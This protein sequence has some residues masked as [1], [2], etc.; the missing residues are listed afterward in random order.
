MAIKNPQPTSAE[1]SAILHDFMGGLDKSPWPEAG[2]SSFVLYRRGKQPKWYR[3]AVCHAYLRLNG[4]KQG[5]EPLAIGSR[6]RV[7]K[8]KDMQ[9][10]SDWWL[11]NMWTADSPWDEVYLK[12]MP[13]LIGGVMVNTPE[14]IK[15]YGFFLYNLNIAGNLLMNFFQASRWQSE[16][17][18]DAQAAYNIWKKHKIDWRILFVFSPLMQGQ[19]KDCPLAPVWRNHFSVGTS[20]FVPQAFVQGQPNPLNLTAP[21]N[22]KGK[23]TGVEDVWRQREIT[24]ADK[25][26]EK[27]DYFCSLREKYK[28]HVKVSQD[29]NDWGEAY[30][31][32]SVTQANLIKIMQEEEKEC[33]N[34]EAA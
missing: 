17:Y 9:E 13:R 29:E 21:Y 8:A 25:Y 18:M 27:E 2:T 15:K 3:T 34:Q 12:N 31:K 16:Y 5:E 7:K 1:L 33:L 22:I 14:F 19:G 11:D 23:M 24:N 4:V 30:T 6:F 26:E 10:V 32:H 28:E 20:G